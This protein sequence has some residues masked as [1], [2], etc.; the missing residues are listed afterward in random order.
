MAELY[1]DNYGDSSAQAC[2][3]LVHLAQKS[4]ADWKRWW[5]A[6]HVGGDAHSSKQRLGKPFKKRRQSEKGLVPLAVEKDQGE[7]K[8]KK[9]QKNLLQ[10]RIDCK[11]K[12]FFSSKEKPN[13]G[14]HSRFLPSNQG[15]VPFFI[16]LS[17][18]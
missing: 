12:I 7:T 17:S 16:F 3:M 6:S 4:V 15:N 10:L 8:E 14:L 18:L 5:A 11:E 9:T 1:T 2:P 13:Q